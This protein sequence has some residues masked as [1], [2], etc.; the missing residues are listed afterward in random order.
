MAQRERMLDGG[1]SARCDGPCPA[2]DFL[3]SAAFQQNPQREVSMKPRHD[4]SAPKK[5]ISLHN[6]LFGD[7]L[8][9]PCVW[10]YAGG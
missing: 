10:C 4:V 3:L 1:R 7:A 5:N 2:G 6:L 9:K 8:C